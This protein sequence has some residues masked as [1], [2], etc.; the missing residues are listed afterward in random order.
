[1]NRELHPSLGQD[2]H[3]MGG[4]ILLDSGGRI[5]LD[6]YSKTNTDRPDVEKTLLPLMRAMH[7]QRKPANN[8]NASGH[9]VAGIPSWERAAIAKE[10]LLGPA[11]K[12]ECKS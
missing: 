2:V 9:G 10:T 11:E 8:A 12:Q 4:D 6:H 7:V 3:R 1:M 5:V